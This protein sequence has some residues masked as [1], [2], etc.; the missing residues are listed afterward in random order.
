MVRVSKNA[1]FDEFS[2]KNILK[3]PKVVFIKVTG[4]NANHTFPRIRKSDFLVMGK[5]WF[6]FVPVTF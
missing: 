5:V 3:G 6:A 2:K 4:P 1:K